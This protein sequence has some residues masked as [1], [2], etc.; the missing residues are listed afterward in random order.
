MISTQVKEFPVILEFGGGMAKENCGGAEMLM[1]MRKRKTNLVE[2]NLI[3]EE[4]FD[5]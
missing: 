2:L 4:T 5:I 3:L 1:R